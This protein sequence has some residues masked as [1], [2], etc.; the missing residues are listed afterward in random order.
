[1]YDYSRLASIF[2]SVPKIWIL[3]NDI[4]CPL[5]FTSLRQIQN[6]I[7]TVVQLAYNH[8]VWFTHYLRKELNNILTLKLSWCTRW[9]CSS[10]CGWTEAKTIKGLWLKKWNH[11]NTLP[12]KRIVISL[13]FISTALLFEQGGL[14]PLTKFEK[15]FL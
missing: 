15:S 5:L 11:Q 14:F 13:S 9:R 10:L 8:L 4:F 3:Y 12:W 6:L 2:V 1:M 7:Q